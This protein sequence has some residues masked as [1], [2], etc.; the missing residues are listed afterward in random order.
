MTTKPVADTSIEK[1]GASDTPGSPGHMHHPT[2]SALDTA[3]VAA[4]DE[5]LHEAALRD[6]SLRVPR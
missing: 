4:H 3:D 5:M 6:S 2:H 1:E